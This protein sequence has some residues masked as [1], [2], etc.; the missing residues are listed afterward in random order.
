MDL[1]SKYTPEQQK[2][3]KRAKVI[4]WIGIVGIIVIG[5]LISIY[6]VF[7]KGTVDT[8]PVYND[9]VKSMLDTSTWQSYT[10]EQYGFSFKFP[11]EW[12]LDVENNHCPF[13]RRQTEEC[14][15]DIVTLKYLDDYHIYISHQGTNHE[16]LPVSDWLKQVKGQ[17]IDYGYELVH[18]QEQGISIVGLDS[19]IYQGAV[20]L[21]FMS[22]DDVIGIE[23]FDNNKQDDDAF[24]TFNN[25]LLSLEFGDV[26]DISD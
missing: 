19:G 8:K 3:V 16:Q 5:L 22:G 17:P 15:N 20:S 9:P 6:F 1:Q 7:I 21:Y 13:A 25:I 10:S 2:Q 18:D 4:L 24:W 14:S 26:A 12:V 11:M 23:W